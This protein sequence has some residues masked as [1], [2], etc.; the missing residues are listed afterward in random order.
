MDHVC[1]I[2][3]CDLHRIFLRTYALEVPEVS[4]VPKELPVFD[5]DLFVLESKIIND[6]VHKHNAVIMGCGGF[7]LSK[8]RPE[9]IHLLI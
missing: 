3:D 7:L 4:Y 5:R 2:L 8:R 6:I 9:T 1:F